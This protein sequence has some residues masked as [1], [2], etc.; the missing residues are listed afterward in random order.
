MNDLIAS[1]G[2]A[3]MAL[4]QP[5]QRYFLLDERCAGDAE[6]T[7]DNLVSALI[8]LEANRDPTRLSALL[9]VLSALLRKQ[10]GNAEL[11]RAFRAWVGGSGWRRT[12]GQSRC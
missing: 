5:S 8:E 6:L 1:G 10:G 11:T 2:T 3:K 7:P 4:Y 9:K 12:S